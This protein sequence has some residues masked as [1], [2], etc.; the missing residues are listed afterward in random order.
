MSEMIKERRCY[1]GEKSQD[2]FSS[3]MAAN[4]EDTDLWLSDREVMGKIHAFRLYGVF[5]DPVTGNIYVF[6]LAGHEV[7]RKYT[8]MT[9]IQLQE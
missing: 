8:S 7:R 4:D 5:F 6:L 9:V 3:L 1:E 2:L